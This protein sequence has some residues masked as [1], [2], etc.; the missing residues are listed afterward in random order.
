MHVL[1]A[2][3][4]SITA[5]FLTAP[6]RADEGGANLYL[7][8]SFASMAAVPGMPGWSTSL[9]YYHSTARVQNVSER[10]DLAYAG[11]TYSLP[12]PVLDGQLSLSLFGAFGG[13]AVA[14][15]DV[16]N[17]S[18]VGIMDLTPAASMRWSAGN[19]NYLVYTLTNVPSGTYNSSRLANFGIGHWGQDAGFGYTYYDKDLGYEL[20]AVAGMTYNFENTKTQYQ[21]GIDAHIDFSASKFIGDQY[22]LGLVGYV[23]QQVTGDRGRGATFGPFKGRVFAAGPQAG[24][25]FPVGDA[26]GYLN[27][28][29]YREFEAENRPAGWNLWLTIAISPRGA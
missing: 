23:Y 15:T 17:D 22:Q 1:A 10:A 13:M 2:L 8:G 16:R 4:A 6:A 28:K 20:S 14:I 27:L 7:A 24:Y 21:N 11:I 3:L 12:T 19:H 5:T 25:L 29:F 18:R 26:Q 9:T